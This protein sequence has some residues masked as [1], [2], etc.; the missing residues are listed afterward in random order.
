MG[1]LGNM[2][3]SKHGIIKDRDVSLTGGNLLN[4]LSGIIWQKKMND[5]YEGYSDGG[6]A[7]ARSWDWAHLNPTVSDVTDMCFRSLQKEHICEGFSYQ[8]RLQRRGKNGLSP[9]V[10]AELLE[11]MWGRCF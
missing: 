9:Y 2:N 11:K 6:T 7:L 10:R 1:A 4:P 8:G 3:G 5:I